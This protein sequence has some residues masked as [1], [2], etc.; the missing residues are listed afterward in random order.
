MIS[1]KEVKHF[2]ATLQFLFD[3]EVEADQARLDRDAHDLR[4]PGQLDRRGQPLGE[5][6]RVPK[7]EAEGG[8]T[9]EHQ[10]QGGANEF[11]QALLWGDNRCDGGAKGCKCG[12]NDGRGGSKGDL[13]QSNSNRSGSAVAGNWNGTTQSNAQSKSPVI[14]YDS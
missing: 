11:I 3:V 4:V 2:A 13:D 5:V 1:G 8:G 6:T 14:E 9:A 10:Q 7:D 12:S